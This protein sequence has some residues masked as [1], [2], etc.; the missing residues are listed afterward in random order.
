MSE[1]MWNPSGWNCTNVCHFI[2]MMPTLLAPHSVIFSGGLKCRIKLI[3]SPFKVSGHLLFK[4]RG[5]SSLR[6]NQ[7]KDRLR[8]IP[9]QKWPWTMCTIQVQPTTSLQIG[10]IQSSLEWSR[11]AD[12]HS[13]GFPDRLQG[14]SCRYWGKA[15]S[16]ISSHLCIWLGPATTMSCLLN[17][18]F[19]VAGFED[20]PDYLAHESWFYPIYLHPIAKVAFLSGMRHN[21]LSLKH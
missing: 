11:L 21:W 9:Q 3:T 4:G 8:H 16:K 7:S 1:G 12:L 13:R 10:W 18:Y 5:F 20:F 6:A 15:A 14:D 17:G 19:Y 2:R